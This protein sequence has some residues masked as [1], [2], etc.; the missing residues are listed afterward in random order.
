V[1]SVLL[2]KWSAY[3]VSGAAIWSQILAQY[4]K[5]G[6][7]V[8]WGGQPKRPQTDV[9]S[10]KM[11]RDARM[12]ALTGC[13]GALW[14]RVNG[15]SGPFATVN[16]QGG[17]PPFAAPAK[18]SSHTGKRGLLRRQVFTFAELPSLDP[19]KRHSI[20]YPHHS[21]RLRKFLSCGITFL[22]CSLRKWRER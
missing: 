14:Q 18:A 5:R 13:A 20:L 8:C 11:L 2:R 22:Y 19:T 17:E 6:H 1:T 16:T 10:S 15:R 12:A 9:S 4:Q 21:T 3:S 7:S